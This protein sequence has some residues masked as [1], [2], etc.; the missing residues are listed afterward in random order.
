MERNAVVQE[1]RVKHV[2]TVVD[3][4]V[5]APVAARVQHALVTKAQSDA[6]LINVADADAVVNFEF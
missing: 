1:L 2:D 6:V 4:H 3:A 5:A